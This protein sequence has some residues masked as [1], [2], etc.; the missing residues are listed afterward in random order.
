MGGGEFK[1]FHIYGTNIKMDRMIRYCVECQAMIK[2]DQNN[3]YSD[4]FCSLR[5]VNK[6]GSSKIPKICKSLFEK[7]AEI[8]GCV[9]F[10]DKD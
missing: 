6:K 4:G 10:V 1:P 5:N 8:G 9:V 3:Y 2:F 7:I